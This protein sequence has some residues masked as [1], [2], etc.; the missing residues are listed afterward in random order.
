[1]GR[2]A[3]VAMRWLVRTAATFPSTFD[4]GDPVWVAGNPGWVRAVTFTRGKVRYAV[5][6]GDV[7]DLSTLHN[8]DS[9]LVAP[10]QGESI[11]LGFDPYS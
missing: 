11:D 4:I 3:V 10:R 7:G 1:M 6:I 5:S 2:S 8:V 9:A